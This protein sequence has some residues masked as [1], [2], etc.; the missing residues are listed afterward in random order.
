[1]NTNVWFQQRHLPE[2][3]SMLSRIKLTQTFNLNK[4][5]NFKTKSKSA[6]KVSESLQFSSSYWY[7]TPKS[8][9]LVHVS[10]KATYRE[11][12]KSKACT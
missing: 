1:M 11:A 4:I 12:L 3:T 10:L 9:F 6:K 5:K 8:Q 2:N 7:I